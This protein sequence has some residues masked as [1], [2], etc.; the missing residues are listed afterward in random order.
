MAL[1]TPSL[2]ARAS[3][4]AGSTTGLL[5]AFAMSLALVV[6]ASAASRHDGMWSVRTAPESGARNSN[7]DFK[8]KVKG[9]KV[10]SAGFWP[11]KATG[12]INKLGV[13]NMTLAHG[14]QRVVAKGLVE[15]DSAS[16]DWTSPQPK[17]SGAGFARRA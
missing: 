3:G 11:V 9:G 7:F 10:T 8:L 17:C 1:L 16:G 4:Q 6:P 14:H 15:G 2:M 5:A 13:V 12:G